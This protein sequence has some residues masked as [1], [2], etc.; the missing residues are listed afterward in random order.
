VALFQAD[1]RQPKFFVSLVPLNMHMGGLIS[2]RRIKEQPVRP[3]AK[4]S[5]QFVS[6]YMADGQIWGGLCNVPAQA[7]DVPP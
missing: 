1:R 4:N 6:V 3:R 7:S 5:W 2:I